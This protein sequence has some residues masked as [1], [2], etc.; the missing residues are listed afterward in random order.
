MSGDNVSPLHGDPSKLRP[1][2]QKLLAQMR[3]GLD[4]A[5]QLELDYLIKGLLYRQGL[6]V[7]YGPSNTGKSFAALNIAHHVAK[8]L[9]WNGRK[10]SKGRVLYL[11]AEGGAAFLN[12]VAALDQPELWV[13]PAPLTLVGDGALGRELVDVALH[14][15][16]V[17]GAPF[18]LIVVDTL[19]RVMGGEDENLA[20]AIAKLIRSLDYIRRATGAHV[21]LVHHSGKDGSRGARGHS[22]LRAAIDTEIALTRGD[23]GPI[24]MEVTKQRDGPTGDKF[25]FTL[26]RAVLGKDQDGD[27]V[28]TCTVGWFAPGEDLA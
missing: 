16:A 28:T 5:P 3:H 12:R 7:L 27:D 8:G 11:A 24:A 6:S 18:D 21:M 15:T 2:A 20:P 10:V 9:R 14:L 13:L 19:A 25:H 4:V 23:Q 17:G 26:L 22:S 1:H